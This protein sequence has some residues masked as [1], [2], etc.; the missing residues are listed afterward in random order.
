[1][2]VDL[3]DIQLEDEEE[4]E[5]RYPKQFPILMDLPEKEE[6]LPYLASCMELDE[7]DGLVSCFLQALC[8]DG[9]EDEVLLEE[10]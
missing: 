1:M 9:G 10:G 4:C 5:G 7:E 2:Y 3:V 8:P 6:A